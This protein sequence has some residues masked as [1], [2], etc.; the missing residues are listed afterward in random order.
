MITNYLKKYFKENRISQYEIAK[1]I[2]LSQGKISLSFN[3]KRK[4]TAEE[5]VKVA[6]KYNIDLNKLKDIK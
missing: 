1:E 5:L 4:L 2:G 3:G 6:K